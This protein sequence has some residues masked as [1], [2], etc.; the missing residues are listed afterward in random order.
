MHVVLIAAPA[1][2][3]AKFDGSKDAEIL[4]ERLQ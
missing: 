4:G 1:F 3:T 2:Y